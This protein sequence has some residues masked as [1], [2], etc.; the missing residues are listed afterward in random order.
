[1]LHHFINGGGGTDFRPVFEYVE[2]YIFDSQIIIY[3]TDGFATFLDNVPLYDAL[4]IMPQK[5]DVP[6]GEVLVMCDKD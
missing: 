1:M 3:F 2:N 5:V 6:F 4:W